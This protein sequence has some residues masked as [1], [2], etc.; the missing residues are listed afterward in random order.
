MQIGKNMTK[1]LKMVY[2]LVLFLSIFLSIIACNSSF[3]TFRDSRC[4][5]D[6]DCPN[7]PGAT[8]RCRK[9]HCVLI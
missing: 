1:T 6:K 5:T 2:V 7:V 3:I 8:G 9:G 4:K